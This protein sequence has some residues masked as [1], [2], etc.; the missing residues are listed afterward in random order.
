MSGEEI[1]KQDSQSLEAVQASVD[2]FIKRYDVTNQLVIETLHEHPNLR[3][4]LGNVNP[5][6]VDMKVLPD[7]STR[8]VYSLTE[9]SGMF[10]LKNPDDAMEWRGIFNHSIGTSRQV[11]YLA[12]RLSRLPDDKV[13]ALG[14]RGYYFPAIRPIILRDFMFITHAGRR[15]W[16]GRHI[17]K[18]IDAAGPAEDIGKTAYELLKRQGASA[19]ELDLMRVEMHADHLAQSIRG[20]RFPNIADNIMTYGDWTFDQDPMTLEARFKLLRDR[21]RASDDVLAI[22]KACGK[23]FEK[24]LQEIVDPDIFDHM[25]HAGPY[26]WETKIR[27]AYCASSGLNMKDVFPGYVAQFPQAV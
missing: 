21:K 7:G 16:D 12:D 13:K 26:E 2:N 24:D 23:T 11:Y 9:G 18:L 17:N 5:E 4:L 25:T 6:P 15:I 19:R 3:F 22:L 20:I 10:G 27:R 1:G 14:E 8:F